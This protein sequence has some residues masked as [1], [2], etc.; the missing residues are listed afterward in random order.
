MLYDL[1][2]LILKCSYFLDEHTTINISKRIEDARSKWELPDAIAC[3]RDNAT[4]IVKATKVVESFYSRDTE[5][6][7]DLSE[8]E[9]TSDLEYFGW[10]SDDQDNITNN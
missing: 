1:K 5:Q 7:G 2:V 4:N 3:V 8:E 6:Q 9:S 10:E